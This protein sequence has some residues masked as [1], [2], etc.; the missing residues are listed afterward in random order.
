[1][2]KFAKYVQGRRHR[3]GRGGHGPLTFLRNNKKKVETKEKKKEVQS[4]N[5]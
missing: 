5:Y 3:G 2:T 4:R 1:M